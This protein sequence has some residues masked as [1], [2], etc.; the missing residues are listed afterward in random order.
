M[1]VYGRIKISDGADG[2]VKKSKGNEFYEKNDECS[3]SDSI[4]QKK[5]KCGF[6]EGT[7]N[8]KKII[9]G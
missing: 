3:Y 8:W 9:Y 5:R 2:L 6:N 4:T 1:L 7:S